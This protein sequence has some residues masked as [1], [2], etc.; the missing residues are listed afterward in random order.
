MEKK[1]GMQAGGEIKC[2]HCGMDAFLVK[3]SLMIDWK[4]TGDILACSSCSKT[5]CEYTVPVAD[6]DKPKD[7]K[8]SKLM[9]LLGTEEEKKLKIETSDD[10]KRF[11]RDCVNFICHPFLSRCCLHNKNVEPMDDCPEFHRKPNP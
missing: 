6:K 10:E 11:C 5:I 1:N 2:P 7:V 8:K 4:K 3:K 9:S